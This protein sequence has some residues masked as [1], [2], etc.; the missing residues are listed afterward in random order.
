MEM[1]LSEERALE[2]T[3]FSASKSCCEMQATDRTSLRGPS[4]LMPILCGPH[5]AYMN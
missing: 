1:L 2:L 5:K 3:G 4:R